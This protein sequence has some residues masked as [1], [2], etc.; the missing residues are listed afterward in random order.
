[1][2]QQRDGAKDAAALE[3]PE[4]LA[5]PSQDEVVED[6]V[7]EPKMTRISDEFSRRSILA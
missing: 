7:S 2:V 1:M 6:D 4:G 3:L 5:R